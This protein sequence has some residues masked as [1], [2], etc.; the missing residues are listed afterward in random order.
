MLIIGIYLHPSEWVAELEEGVRG[1]TGAVVTCSSEVGISCFSGGGVP[2]FC[3]GRVVCYSICVEE[4]AFD[5][6][7]GSGVNWATM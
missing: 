6:I 5:S 4:I 1:F 7:T 3:R 2:C